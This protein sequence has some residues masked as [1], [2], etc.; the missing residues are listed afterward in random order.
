MEH[1]AQD[2]QRQLELEILKKMPTAS[3]AQ[4]VKLASDN[5]KLTKDVAA[6]YHKVKEVEGV[7]VEVDNLLV[8]YRTQLSTTSEEIKARDLIIAEIKSQ[9]EKAKVAQQPTTSGLQTNKRRRNKLEGDTDDDALALPE[10]VE[11]LIADKFQKV[12]EQ[13]NNMATALEQI[14]TAR[15]F[16]SNSRLSS[17]TFF[18]SKSSSTT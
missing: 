5:R 15:K 2:L 12:E 17:G 14:R 11:R 10:Q 1:H 6:L 4:T 16:T 7:K 9:L 18:I 8:Q 13:Q 3:A